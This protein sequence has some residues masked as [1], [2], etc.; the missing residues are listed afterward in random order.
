MFDNAKRI[1]SFSGKT[2]SGHAF[3]RKDD[4][5]IVLRTWRKGI[6]YGD[7]DEQTIVI[8]KDIAKHFRDC[9]IS[10]VDD[11]FR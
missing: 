5:C 7:G 9:L 2:H 8:Q 6:R 4:D 3:T 10:L 11:V 1:I